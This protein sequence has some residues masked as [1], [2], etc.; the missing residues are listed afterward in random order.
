M[1]GDSPCR[2][3]VF[4]NRRGWMGCEHVAFDMF[5]TARRQDLAHGS[6]RVSN[7]IILVRATAPDPQHDRVNATCN[8]HEPSRECSYEHDRGGMDICRSLA[9][10]SKHDNRPPL[11][12]SIDLCTRIERRVC[13][14]PHELH[15]SRDT[16]ATLRQ[17]SIIPSYQDPAL[18]PPFRRASS[19]QGAEES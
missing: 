1:A 8:N 3:A 16:S 18:T 12:V 6:P 10:T 13:I 4:I 14:I 7:G 2:F 15:P 11:Q 5:R 19:F 9:S 17:P